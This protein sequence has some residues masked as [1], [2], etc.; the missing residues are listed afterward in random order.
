MPTPLLAF[1]G[2][3]FTGS[4]DAMEVLANNGLDTLL[5]LR[6][7]AADEIEAARER[8]DAIGIAG[9]SRARSVAWMDRELPACFAALKA[10]GAALCHY[11]VCSTFDSSPTVGN[12]G[13][14]IEI[15]RRSLGSSTPVPLVVGAPAMRRY[16]V[17][18]QLFAGVG[19][20]TYRIDRHPTMSVHPVTPMD[21]ADLRVHLGRQAPLRVGLLDAVALAQPDAAQRLDAAMAGNDVILFDVLDDA[22]QARTGELVWSMAKAG[23]EPLF[24]VGSSGVEYA[25]AAHW[26][27]LW[28][29]RVRPVDRDA[30]AVDRIVVVSGSCSPVTAAQIRHALR[31]GFADLRADPVALISE[32]RHEAESARLLAGAHAALAQGLSPLIYTAAGPGDPEVA[33]LNA[34]LR[35]QGRDPREALALMGRRQGTLLR[36][37][38]HDTG[39]GRAVVCGG[40]TS[41]EVVQ[42]LGLTALR[43]KAR[44]APGAPL[45]EAYTDTQAAPM[46]EIALKGGQIGGEDYFCAARDGRGDGNP[47]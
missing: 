28:P 3:D 19:G 25:L 20:V 13:R 30:D 14:A 8:H 35:S 39:L 29:E 31:N 36:R 46:L 43:M 37:L 10:T 47:A 7:P 27:K 21:E 42:V 15:G 40:D 11:K 17:F 18:G 5:F 26:R 41:G 38:L 9:T 32:D 24:C 44:L 22:T 33:R 45:C 1:Y 2:D 23:G 16:T 6:L 4:T 12:I 34:A